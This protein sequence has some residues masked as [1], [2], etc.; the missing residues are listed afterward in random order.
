MAAMN[1]MAARVLRQ[2][3]TAMKRWLDIGYWVAG[4]KTIQRTNMYTGN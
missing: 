4:K 1:G 2:A 3:I